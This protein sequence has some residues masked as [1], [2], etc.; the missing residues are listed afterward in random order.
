MF[1]HPGCA[2][3]VLLSANLFE[4]QPGAPDQEE[5]YDE[6]DAGGKFQTL[7]IALNTVENGGG[8]HF[9]SVNAIA[10]AKRGLAAMWGGGI[11]HKGLANKSKHTRW[12]LSL[13]L[14]HSSMPLSYRDVNSAE[15][16]NMGHFNDL[17][18]GGNNRF[19]LN[20]AERVRRQKQGQH[21]GG[22]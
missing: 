14:V 22:P 5:H 2:D 15:P 18:S 7:S 8:T 20:A 19:R 17:I 1:N 21:K 9:R 3:Y 4:V 6:K 16:V 10:H 12:F 11:P 13:V